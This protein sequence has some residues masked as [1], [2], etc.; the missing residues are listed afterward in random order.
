VSRIENMAIRQVRDTLNVIYLDNEPWQIE[1]QPRVQPKS[2]LGFSSSVRKMIEDTG[3]WSGEY[4]CLESVGCDDTDCAHTPRPVIDIPLVVPDLW[5]FARNPDHDHLM[6]VAVEIED[7][8]PISEEKLARFVSIF[9]ALD[10]VGLNIALVVA[11]R[12]GQSVR[13]VS[14][15]RAAYLSGDL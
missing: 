11:D 7:T 1:W 10:D 8:N 5:G 6:V 3:D 13:T 14:L 12:Y 2:G 9:H 15:F 4:E